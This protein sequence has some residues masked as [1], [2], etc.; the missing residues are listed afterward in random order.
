MSVS[1]KYLKDYKVVDYQNPRLRKKLQEQRS[2]GAVVFFSTLF[3][4]LAGAVYFFCFSPFFRIEKI[5]VQSSTIAPEAVIEKAEEQM[6]SRFLFIFSRKNIWFFS[7][8]QLA[9]EISK[10]YFLDEL[11]IK[12]YY[13]K[14]I[15]VYLKEKTAVA[16]WLRAD[17]C[18]KVDSV[19][20]IIGF[21]QD[22]AAANIIQIRDLRPALTLKIKDSITTAEELKYIT[23]LEQGFAQALGLQVKSYEFLVAQ[24]ELKIYLKQGPELFL[25]MQKPAG[26]IISKLTV[27]FNKEISKNKL[28]G[29]GYID[30]RFGE[31]IYYQ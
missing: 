16:Y 3:I 12:K 4:A 13:P 6:S 21:C 9:A 31:K 19:G 2:R 14:Q 24:N 28:G 23:T 1:L 25:N 30:L 5:N 22:A 8:A 15:D 29:I 26:D 20:A 7:T 18:Y 10:N 27:L 17:Q 11:V